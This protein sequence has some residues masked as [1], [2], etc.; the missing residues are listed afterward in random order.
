MT[1]DV[2]QLSGYETFILNIG[3][4]S[5]LNKYSFLSKSTLFIIDEG[6]DVVDKENVKKLKILTS[7]LLNNYKHI[8]LIS[9]MDHI[10]Y[11]EDSNISIQNN[12]VSSHFV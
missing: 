3:L 12:G 6:L 8:L 10:K 5:A 4:K 1:L 2:N 9:H 11:L 7:Y